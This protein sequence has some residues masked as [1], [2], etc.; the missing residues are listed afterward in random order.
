MP[1]LRNNGHIVLIQLWYLHPRYSAV[2]VK[3]TSG[4][5]YSEARK[6]MLGNIFISE[7]KGI[8]CFVKKSR[9]SMTYTA[10]YPPL[11]SCIEQCVICH[12]GVIG[13][14]WH[15]TQLRKGPATLVH[16]SAME[17]ANYIGTL[18][19]YRGKQLYFCW[20]TQFLK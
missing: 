2:V 7:T 18:H 16:Y 11:Y 19:S 20:C 12:W 10:V 3:K 5:S 14:I 9:R 15:I 1:Y 6:Y 4:Y 8:R 17:R 13:D